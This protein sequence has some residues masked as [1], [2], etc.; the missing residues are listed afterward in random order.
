M[1]QFCRRFPLEAGRGS[2]R[3]ADAPGFFR[4]QVLLGQGHQLDHQFVGLARVRA[5][6]EHAVRQQHHANRVLGRLSR[7]FPRA[8]G[9]EIEA[10]HDV[11]DHHHLVAVDVAHALLA[12]RRIGD[13][14]HRIGVRVV[15]VLVR[16]D[17]VQDGFHRRRRRAR[18]QRVRGKLV[19]HLRIRQAGQRREP[20]HVI[21]LDRREARRL[22]GLHVPAAALHVQDVFL[23]AEQVFLAQLD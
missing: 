2:R 5:E 23:L 9:G 8:A 13:R 7:K 17:G 1:A 22:D 18:A 14:Q 10:G 11:R 4:L 21:Q 12:V 3:Q 20:P 19:D 16:K 6:R 15:H